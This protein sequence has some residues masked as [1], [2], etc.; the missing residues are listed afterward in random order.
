MK[1]RFSF[2]AD[3]VGSHQ[4]YS[5]G[6]G[7]NCNTFF[8]LLYCIVPVITRRQPQFFFCGTF[9]LLT[10]ESKLQLFESLPKTR[11][12]PPA[13]KNLRLVMTRTIASL[14]NLSFPYR[15]KSR[16]HQATRKLLSR[17]FF[18]SHHDIRDAILCLMSS[19]QG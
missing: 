16:R 14:S 8:I 13:K 17:T 7:M 2:T 1:S 11:N 4:E 18:T 9:V 15:F 12:N 5:C 19:G 10:E 3:W 6:N